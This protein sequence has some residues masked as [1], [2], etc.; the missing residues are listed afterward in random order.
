MNTEVAT[1]F[2]LNMQKKTDKVIANQL[3]AHVMGASFLLTS[4]GP[5]GTHAYN[6]FLANGSEIGTKVSQDPRMTLQ[7]PV[8]FWEDV[9]IRTDS[10]QFLSTLKQA[11]KSARAG[12]VFIRNDPPGLRDIRHFL[13]SAD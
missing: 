7:M 6:Y 8:P 10:T 12:C 2:K 5:L 4:S 3:D 1:P 11:L 13:Q 9:H